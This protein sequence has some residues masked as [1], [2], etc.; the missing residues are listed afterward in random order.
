MEKKGR[1]SAMDLRT[2]K[3]KEWSGLQQSWESERL[4]GYRSR[5]KGILEEED[6]RSMCRSRGGGKFYELIKKSARRNKGLLR[7]N[8][9][10]VRVIE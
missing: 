1:A 10:A 8:P 5:K 2:L 9:R 6:I 7:L 4:K 3:E